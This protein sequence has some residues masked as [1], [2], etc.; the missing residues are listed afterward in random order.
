MGLCAAR[1]S[2]INGKAQYSKTKRH[3]EAQID[4]GWDPKNAHFA[5]DDAKQI[6]GAWK[7]A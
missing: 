1:V 6:H 4:N 5:V 7:A 2:S 3:L